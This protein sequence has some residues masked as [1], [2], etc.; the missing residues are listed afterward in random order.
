MRELIGV[1]MLCLLGG[2][3]VGTPAEASNSARSHAVCL[4]PSGDRRRRREAHR[5][6]PGRTR[7]VL[8]TRV[9]GHWRNVRTV[10]VR[11]GRYRTEVDRTEQDQQ[12]RTRAGR[13]TSRT[14]TVAARIPTDACGTQPRKANGTYWSCSFVDDFTGTALN[15]TKWVPQ[16]IF[17]TATR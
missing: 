14:R 17:A 12:F 7:V 4:E 11:G 16:T 9:N 6:R 1:T 13:A 15:R 5:P 8:Q 3:L 10:K 2:L